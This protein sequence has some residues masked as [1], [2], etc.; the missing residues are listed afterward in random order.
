MK[1]RHFLK[2]AGTTLALAG[3]G[4]N[5]TLAAAADDFRWSHASASALVGQSF[6]LNHPELGAMAITLASLRVPATR[7]PDPRLDQFSLV[8]RAPAGPRIADG[9]YEMDHPAL[10]RF[11][12]HLVPAGQDADGASYRSDFTLLT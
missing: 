1:R 8:F 7:T 2:S 11:A 9:T 4:L 3:L 6:W 5:T 12:L 10:G